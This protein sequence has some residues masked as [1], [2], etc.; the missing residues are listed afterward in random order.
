M[1]RRYAELSPE[2]LD[3]ALRDRP[4]AILPIG[5]LE[6]HGPHLPLGLDGIVAEWFCA[7]L[8]E[9]TSG[10]LLPCLWTPITTLPHEYSLDFSSEH[11]SP[12]FLQHFAQ[13]ARAGFRGICCVSGHYAQG[14]V[15]C[16][17]QAALDAMSESPELA[18][19][20]GA[21]L[22]LLGDDSLLDHAARWETAQLLAIRPDLVHT[23][24]LPD[25]LSPRR[26]AI[27]GEDP[28][29]GTAP[30]GFDVLEKS[31]VLWSREAKKLLDP[32]HRAEL[33]ALTQTRM[34]G[35]AEYESRFK[36]AGA[37]WEE[38]IQS[39]WTLKP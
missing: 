8:A 25:D 20:V 33:V 39:W 38:A 19:L 3:A 12:L 17:Y 13:L 5:A 16:L 28:R 29:L 36:P 22:D 9:R 2:E 18:V 31:I 27:L 24:Q 7:Q 21:P 34:S 6:W 15:V 35:Y 4:L 14:H 10:V 26:A 11:M 23:E 30:E 32:A 1:V 37:T